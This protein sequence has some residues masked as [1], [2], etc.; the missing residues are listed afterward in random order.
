MYGVVVLLNATEFA[1][2]WMHPKAWHYMPHGRTADEYRKIGEALEIAAFRFAV[3]LIEYYYP[4]KSEELQYRF[5]RAAYALY[6]ENN[7]KELGK[8]LNISR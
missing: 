2:W 8:L 1:D 5:R 3:P 7:I 4:G 6:D